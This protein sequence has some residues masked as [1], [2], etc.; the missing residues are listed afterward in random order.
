MADAS[1]FYKGRVKNNIKQKWVYDSLVLLEKNN[2]NKQLD[3]V[4]KYAR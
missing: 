4:I 1:K 2:K 3:G